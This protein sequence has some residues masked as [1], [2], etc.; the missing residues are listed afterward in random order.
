MTS[1][2]PSSLKHTPAE[3][4]CVSGSELGWAGSPQHTRT[5][6][7]RQDGNIFAALGVRCS[8]GVAVVVQRCLRSR[9]GNASATGGRRTTGHVL[10]GSARCSCPMT[11]M[12]NIHPRY[13]CVG[14]GGGCC[15]GVVP[16]KNRESVKRKAHA[17]AP[18]HDRNAPDACYGRD[19]SQIS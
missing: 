18:V 7:E 19:A 15:S 5:I 13:L 6:A 8:L 17:V 10:D 12:P 14:K 4:C 2:R 11:G 1:T 16:R 9:I 3:F